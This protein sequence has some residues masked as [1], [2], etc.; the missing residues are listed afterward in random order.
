MQR[1][2]A[3]ESTPIVFFAVLV[4]NLPGASYLV[5]FKDIAA[6]HHHTGGTI[7]RVVAF[8]LIMFVLA[9]VPLIGLIVNPGGTEEAVLKLNCW[10]SENGRRIAIVLCFILSVFLTVRG[11][12]K[13]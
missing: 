1:V 5:A 3:R 2:L 10:F 12:A 8:N 7:F 13:A 4:V 9:E 6:A 11:I